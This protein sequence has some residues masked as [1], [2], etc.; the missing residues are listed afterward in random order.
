MYDKMLLESIIHD[1]LW[2]RHKSLEPLDQV[3]RRIVQT[4]RVF[5]SSLPPGLTIE[6]EKELDGWL[7]SVLP[8]LIRKAGVREHPLKTYR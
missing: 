4:V 6:T 2:R 3:D 1:E 7:K 5:I 8:A